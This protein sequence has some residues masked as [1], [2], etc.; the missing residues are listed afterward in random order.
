M[1]WNRVDSFSPEIAIVESFTTHLISRFFEPTFPSSDTLRWA[2]VSGV[3]SHNALSITSVI[4]GALSNSAPP[5]EPVSV[6]PWASLR[7]SNWNQS[8]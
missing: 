8:W 6:E 7:R 5:L 4:R 1:V 2:K 3:M